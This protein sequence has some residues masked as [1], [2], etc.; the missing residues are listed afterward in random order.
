MCGGASNQQKQEAAQQQQFS[1]QLMAENTTQ[2][3]QQQ[4]ILKTLTDAYTPILQAGPSQEGF[5]QAEKTA[6]NT[7]AMDSSSNAYQNADKA[8][9]ENYAGAGGGTEY[10]PS[11]AQEQMNMG[12][13]TAGAEQLAGAQN[14]ITQA[15]YAQGRQNF[16]DASNVLAGASGQLGTTGATADAAT[17]SAKGA[18]SAASQNTA[19]NNAWMG[20][21]G[22]ALGGVAS[23]VNYSK[24]GGFGLGG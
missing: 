6:M 24:D 1:Q 3:G 20:A 19:Q 8:L 5:S 9:N 2:F 7:Q 23:N 13:A 21:L 12:V 18:Y 11:G 10:I 16:A 22:S 17:N 15:D 4:G 14:Q